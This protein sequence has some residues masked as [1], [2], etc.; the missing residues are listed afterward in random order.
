MGKRKTKYYTRDLGVKVRWRRLR[1][2]TEKPFLAWR[3]LRD[4]KWIYERLDLPARDK[5]RPE[6]YREVTENAKRAAANR[7][8]ELH[9]VGRRSAAPLPSE[10]G[11]GDFLEYVAKLAAGKQSTASSWARLQM[12]LKHH[13]GGSV[14]FRAINNGWLRDFKALLVSRPEIPGR[15]RNQRP[16]SAGSAALLW[17]TLRCAL[18]QAVND[19]HLD[20]KILADAGTI[21]APN[22]ERSFLTG[23]ETR[24]LAELEIPAMERKNTLEE[25]RLAFLAS[26]R[27]G[28]RWSDLLSLRWGEIQNDFIVKRQKKTKDSVRVA[29]GPT[30]RA[31]LAVQR[32]RLGENV[33]PH[34]EALV[35][36]LPRLVTANN[37]IRLLARLAGITKHI[38]WHAA[39]HSFAVDLLESG[40][41]LYTTSK[42]LGHSSISVT[43]Q[44]LHIVDK[45]KREAVERLPAISIGR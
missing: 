18:R 39:R 20:S 28:L 6:Q 30:M 23:D 37:G 45:R 15:K 14:R 24:K 26:C 17:Q 16:L 25:L 11:K 36:K 38:S 43:E 4:R 1:D 42:L 13:T 22:T 21:R 3:D 7:G 2:G 8:V 34:P 9:K 19:G 10:A 29:I 41:D 31:I 40:A 35:F 33:E 27:T 5:A 32:E 44:Y 12:Y